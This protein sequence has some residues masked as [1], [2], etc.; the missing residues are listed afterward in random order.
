MSI[1]QFNIIDIEA[2]CWRGR[3]PKNFSQEVIEIGIVTLDLRTLKII[4]PKA[5]SYVYNSQM[6]ISKFCEELTG[7]N[8]GTLKTNG[9]SLETTFQHLKDHFKVHKIPW[10]SW[11]NFDR[12]HLG[13]EC[14]RKNIEYPFCRT[15]INLK[16][17][18]SMLKGVYYSCS[19]STALDLLNMSF[20]GTPHSGLDDAFN[21]ARILANL[22]EQFRSNEK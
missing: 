7:I 4:K 18:F 10:G 3:P 8:K 6:R 1:E 22:L 9:S 11:G 16:H 15:H 5:T 12:Q 21:V 14:H 13:R 2:T 20:E 17:Q 19:V